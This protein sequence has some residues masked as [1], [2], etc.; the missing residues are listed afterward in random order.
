MA[1]HVE[2]A[3]ALAYSRVKVGLRS[4]SAVPVT[5]T[6][7]VTKPLLAGDVICAIGLS[8][9]TLRLKFRLP[10][11]ETTPIL[12]MWLPFGY[13]GAPVA[14]SVAS[15]FQDSVVWPLVM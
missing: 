15:V 2:G 7:L 12:R 8:T 10:K 5:S 13:F 3:V 9:L 14:G 11:A 6:D 4:P 1:I